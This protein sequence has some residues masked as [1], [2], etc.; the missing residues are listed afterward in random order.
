MATSLPH[1]DSPAAPPKAAPAPPMSGKNKLAI[2]NLMSPPDNLLETFNHRQGR[3]QQP[4]PLPSIMDAV[5]TVTADNGRHGRS[6]SHNEHPLPMSPPISPFTNPVSSNSGG[7]N[8]TSGGSSR[9]SGDG[10]TPSTTPS[11]AIQDPVLYPVDEYPPSS[12][13]QP[14][15]FA[16]GDIQRSEPDEVNPVWAQMIAP[17]NASPGSEEVVMFC[18]R[19][20]ELYLKDP[21]GWLRRER[22][23]LIADRK[24]RAERRQANQPAKPI[25][26]K[27]ARS[28][29][30]ADRVSK[31][32]ASA[33]R[34][35]RSSVAGLPSSSAAAIPR[36]ASRRR[37]SATPDPSRRIV[38][39]NREDKDFRSLPDY[40]P[41][42][43][44]LPNK[45]NSLKV[46]WKGQPIDLT[47]DPNHHLLH[48]DEIV[49]ASNLRLDCATY[50][51]S[52]R[53]IFERRLQCLRT[54]KEF[55]KTDAQQAC[56]IDVN[57]ASK[58]WTAFDKVGWLNAEWVRGYL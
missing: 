44:S 43:T 18:P 40:C 27:P 12:P 31:P 17:N 39:P 32:Q 25:A 11:Q 42:L 26:A 47:N 7:G 2:S 1:G 13:V 50:L 23:Y 21:R 3:R 24:A 52:K 8:S 28:Q 22:D 41:P 54:G 35:I 15:L 29:R 9:S 30:A 14:P 55:R 49:L 4:A 37:P 48:P 56:K 33:P 10:N 46:D 34:P 16:S 45:A 19:I 58:L 5:A 6:A 53:R 38:A 57:K 36:P 51:T 20:M